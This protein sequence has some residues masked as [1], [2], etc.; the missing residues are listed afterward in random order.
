MT[1]NNDFDTISQQLSR[2][3]LSY[4]STADDVVNAISDLLIQASALNDHHKFSDDEIFSKLCELYD[5]PGKIT[6]KNFTKRL[7]RYFNKLINKASV[8]FQYVNKEPIFHCVSQN[9]VERTKALKGRFYEE[10]LYD[11]SAKKKNHAEAARHLSEALGLAS[12][13]LKDGLKGYFLTVTLKGEK[14]YC[15]GSRWDGTSPAAGASILSKAMSSVRTKASKIGLKLEYFRTINPHEKD[16]AA[17]LHSCLFT[18]DQDRLIG[19]I[20]AAF[21]EN[22]ASIDIDEIRNINEAVLYT[23]K[24]Q[25][26]L[27]TKDGEK[28]TLARKSFGVRTFSKSSNVRRMAPVSLV[29]ACRKGKFTS[30]RDQAA[31]N[32]YRSLLPQELYSYSLLALARSAQTYD[33]ADCTRIY[34][35][36]THTRNSSPTHTSLDINTSASTDTSTLNWLY[37]S[38]DLLQTSSQGGETKMK[39]LWDKM[40]VFG[41]QNDSFLLSIYEMLSELQLKHSPEDLNLPDRAKYLLSCI[42]HASLSKKASEIAQKA[43]L[44]LNALNQQKYEVGINNLKKAQLLSEEKP[45]SLYDLLIRGVGEKASTDWLRNVSRSE[46]HMTLVFDSAPDTYCGFSIPIAS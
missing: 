24:E 30:K 33:Y 45:K 26:D 34:S 14:H 2:F 16:G 21:P 22:I 38:R 28:R 23:V 37:Q 15:S 1:K 35:L 29:E 19:F 9:H 3:E 4:N 10:F 36:F 20:K 31:I 43:G 27:T 8:L 40:D 46:S 6:A 44:R 11:Y 5:I 18:D 17:H 42:G 39:K 12:L 32:S 7:K 13:A 41:F 25:W